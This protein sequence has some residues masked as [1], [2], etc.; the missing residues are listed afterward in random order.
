MEKSV[1]SA[2]VQ[3]RQCTA[4]DKKASRRYQKALWQLDCLYQ[5]GTYQEQY[6]AVLDRLCRFLGNQS[7]HS[8]LD[9]IYGE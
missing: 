5:T 4:D 9:W 7:F 3:Y 1:E 2:A 6:D 8:G